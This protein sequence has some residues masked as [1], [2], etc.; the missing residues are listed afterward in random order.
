MPIAFVAAEF[1]HPDHDGLG[2]GADGAVTVAEIEAP[3]FGGAVCGGGEEEFGVEGDGDGEGRE[4]V[5]VES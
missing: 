4:G 5:A 1:E 3:D 2:M